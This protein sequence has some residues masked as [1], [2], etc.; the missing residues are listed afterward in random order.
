MSNPIVAV[1]C[2]K[3]TMR[4]E[5]ER[6]FAITNLTPCNLNNCDGRMEFQFQDQLDEIKNSWSKLFE[7]EQQQ[8][9]LFEETDCLCGNNRHKGW[10]NKVGGDMICED[11]DV[12]GINPMISEQ[13][14]E[15][16]EEPPK[17][18]CGYDECQNEVFICNNVPDW[19]ARWDQRQHEFCS[20][21][22]YD[23]FNELC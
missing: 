18:R 3:C 17:K 23:T 11:C 15:D 6:Y 19:C 8:E 1:Q 13:T 21:E 16:K 5:D 2:T 22:C 10:L 4:C 12:D 20:E 14:L 9:K 7:R